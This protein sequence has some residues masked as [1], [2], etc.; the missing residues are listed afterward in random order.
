[1]AKRG[2]LFNEK[3][4]KN[5]VE[6]S[7]TFGEALIRLGL[8]AHADNYR[9]I[10]EASVRYDVKLKEEMATNSSK[11]EIQ[12]AL[13][14]SSSMS[15]MCKALGLVP[16]TKS[17]VRIVHDANIYGLAIPDY[18]SKNVI[19]QALTR[20]NRNV[21]DDEIED[22]VVT[23]KTIL[24]V[25]IK[26]KLP[27]TKNT[28]RRIRKIAEEMGEEIP[29]RLE[30]QTRPKL[31]AEDIL[32]KNSPASRS[33][34]KSHIVSNG[35]LDNSKCSEC[36]IVE[37]NNAPIS[38]HLDHINGINNDNRIENLRFLCPNCHSQTETYCRRG[39]YPDEPLE[40]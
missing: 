18:V 17:N 14:S 3:A 7:S 24:D 22:A 35:L 27:L 25:V 2:I 1:M 11:N 6:K 21:T 40:S 20:L 4:V 26:M 37:W 10:R 23:E 33:G 34:I 19:E 36:G 16:A 38:L 8:R 29:Y 28:V 9:R 32:V 39:Q 13:E 12:S 31:R 30:S 15:E 5:A